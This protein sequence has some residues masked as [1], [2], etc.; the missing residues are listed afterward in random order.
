MPPPA[1]NLMEPKQSYESKFGSLVSAAADRGHDGGALLN[2]IDVRHGRWHSA[3]SNMVWQS[4]DFGGCW[5]ASTV[6]AIQVSR[7]LAVRARFMGRANQLVD[8][9]ASEEMPMID[10]ALVQECLIEVPSYAGG[11][12]RR[13]LFAALND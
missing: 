11:D 1:G 9:G 6:Q 12:T 3:S 7:K 8:G 4:G 13:R 5:C 10:R 2:G